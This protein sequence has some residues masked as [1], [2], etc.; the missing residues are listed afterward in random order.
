VSTGP[1]L[2]CLVAGVEKAARV[3]REAAAA[4]ARREP[5]PD[6]VQRGDLAIEVLA[7]RP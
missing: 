5:I 7:P 4:D 6:R 3:D 2:A 1:E